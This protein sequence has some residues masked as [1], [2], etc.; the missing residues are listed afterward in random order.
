MAPATRQLLIL[1][2]GVDSVQALLADARQDAARATVGDPPEPLV[3][4][5]GAERV[6]RLELRAEVEDP[7]DDGPG[8]RVHA[9]IPIGDAARTAARE[10]MQR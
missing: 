7:R 6:E 10:G 2:N 3:P 5:L 4:P 9:V 1:V 8:F